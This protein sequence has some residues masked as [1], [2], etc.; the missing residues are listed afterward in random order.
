[1]KRTLA[2]LLLSAS[3]VFGQNDGDTLDN[4]QIKRVP[5]SSSGKGKLLISEGDPT[6]PTGYKTL[7]K[8]T[9]NDGQVVKYDANGDVAPGSV[10]ASDVGLGNVDNTSDA[11][12][13]VST[14]TQTLLDLKAEISDLEQTFA[15]Y[16]GVVPGAIEQLGVFSGAVTG[17]LSAKFLAMLDQLTQSTENY[18]AR[19]TVTSPVGGQDGSTFSGWGG[20]FDASSIQAFTHVRIP[21][22]SRDPTITIVDDKWTSIAIEITDGPLPSGTV[23]ATGSVVVDPEVGTI[24]DLRIRVLDLNGDPVSLTSA[25]FPS[26]TMGVGFEARNDIDDARAGRTTAA[27]NSL[28]LTESYYSTNGGTQ[29]FDW[30]NMASDITPSFVFEAVGYDFDYTADVETAIAQIDQNA[31]SAAAIADIT[32]ADTVPVNS[33]SPGPATS[34]SSTFSGWA[35]NMNPPTSEFG[36]VK[37]YNLAQDPT[38]L[39]SEKW[40]KIVFRLHDA[41]F[42]H[43]GSFPGSNLVA[44]AEVSVDPNI[45]NYSELI[46]PQ[47][48]DPITGAKLVLDASDFPSGNMGA[49]FVALTATDTRAKGV[50]RAGP[51]T[52][53]LFDGDS[54]Y[55][56]T[57]GW[58]DDVGDDE[59]AFEF[60]AADLVYTAIVPGS[61]LDVLDVPYLYAAEAREMNVYFDN[62]IP[63]RFENYV[64]DTATNISL[65]DHQE[66]RW[67]IVPTNAQ[68]TS[69]WTLT[70]T[71][72]TFN[73][74]N[75][76]L[77]TQAIQ[78]R[79]APSAN[80]TGITR[81]LLGIGDSTMANSIMMTELNSVATADVYGLTLVGTKGTPPVSHEG[82]SG[83]TASF[84]ATDPTSPFFNGGASLDIPGYLSANSIT[85]AADDW[86]LINLGIND[87]FGQTS[88]SGAQ[89]IADA[90]V[91]HYTTLINAF[92]AHEAGLRFAICLTIPPCAMQSAFGDNYLSGQTQARYKQNVIVVNREL[93]ASFGGRE[94]EDLYLC[95]ITAG[96]DPVW[97]FPYI[98]EAANSRASKTITR[99]TN[100]VHPSSE[101]YA[102]IADQV[103]A[104]LKYH[105]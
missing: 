19:N 81:R 3:F 61:T 7:S 89:A 99:W 37:L 46:F 72:R 39:V 22:L 59:Q 50:G 103:F 27:S 29:G 75:T 83:K 25:D 38:V 57:G 105:Q 16:V 41:D 12:K 102:Q 15:D 71:P 35:M 47:F 11:D 84:F 67:T 30:F 104:F 24:S 85:L 93:I 74:P 42:S 73:Q 66:E 36:R 70:I 94:A 88:D 23:V 52:N 69:G 43:L 10:T 2:L 6:D 96:L 33:V 51:G 21:I 18:T 79:G 58:F 62:L 31:E 56:T 9:G 65:G 76:A 91:V 97:N 63:G 54:Y 60:A 49:S 40:S 100:G 17:D 77:D 5:E 8:L 68:A 53:S 101:G 55:T 95:P 90:M 13:P 44:I 34:V 1:M 80:G 98:E 32:S 45:T 87:V 64:W 20:D 78:V 48:E 14:A 28:F 92:K 82:I 26:G 86:V 4:P